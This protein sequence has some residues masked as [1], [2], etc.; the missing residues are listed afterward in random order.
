MNFAKNKK[1]RQCTE[2]GPRDVEGEIGMKQGDWI[3]SS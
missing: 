2:A 3:C 1:C